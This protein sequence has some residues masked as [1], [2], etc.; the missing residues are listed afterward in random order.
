MALKPKLI[1][2]RPVAATTQAKQ[3]EFVQATSKALTFAQR[4]RRPLIIGTC[5]ALAVLVG[6]VAARSY[7]EHHG[8][9]RSAAFSIAVAGSLANVRPA[10]GV[11]DA[12]PAAA[13]PAAAT[14][15]PAKAPES[16][17][18]LTERAAYSG[19]AYADYMQ[20]F[21]QDGELG[22]MARLGAASTAL[23][24]GKQA[25]GLAALVALAAD[26]KLPGRLRLFVLDTLGAA[27][28][29]AGKL[30][31]AE[32][33]YGEIATLEGGMLAD[34]A[35]LQKGR[36]AESRGEVADARKTYEAALKDHPEGA[37][38]DEIKKRLDLL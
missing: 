27:Q 25:E 36:I 14:T 11:P 28:L 35:A 10:A 38:K 7:M 4:H 24:Q 18:S 12:P 17:G 16:F 1:T 13:A 26:P 9:A 2:R 6:V 33:T 15:S 19:K 29:D 34:Y 5:A 21:G 8:Q 31:E 30:A 23:Q 32:K 20:Q 22:H 37:F 3:D